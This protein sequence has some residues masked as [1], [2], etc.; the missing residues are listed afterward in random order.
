MFEQQLV[1]LAKLTGLLKYLSITSGTFEHDDSTFTKAGAT[2]SSTFAVGDKIVIAGTT[3]NNGTFTV[4]AIEAEVITFEE[5]I[6]DE[7]SNATLSGEAFSDWVDIK[8]FVKLVGSVNID[9]AG[10]LYVDQSNDPEGSVRGAAPAGVENVDYTTQLSVVASTPLS[11]S[12]EAIGIWAR[13]RV[14]LNATTA[15]TIHRSYLNGR[16]TT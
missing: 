7:T 11:F 16:L 2:F 9:Q 1:R 15:L 12:I 4:A 14:Q 13:M 3:Y 10:I 6:A 8:R 5:A